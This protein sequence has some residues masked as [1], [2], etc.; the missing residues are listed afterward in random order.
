MIENCSV[1]ILA[2]DEHSEKIIFQLQ[3]IVRGQKCPRY[4]WKGILV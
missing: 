4:K 2:H 3:A 1:G